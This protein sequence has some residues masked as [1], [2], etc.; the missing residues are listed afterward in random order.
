MHACVCAHVCVYER[1][2][3]S[4]HWHSV[5]GTDTWTF[6]HSGHFKFIP[7]TH[8]LMPSEDHEVKGLKV[9]TASQREREMETG[10]CV[11]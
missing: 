3:V 9:D 8:I 4:M 7:S 10:W 5:E 11:Q 2:C 6:Q 1:V